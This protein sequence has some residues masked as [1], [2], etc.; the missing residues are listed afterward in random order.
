MKFKLLL[1]LGL[2]FLSSCQQGKK[3]IDPKL[4]LFY[5]EFSSDQVS[6]FEESIGY[7]DWFL[8]F[9]YPE[10]QSYGSSV[11]SFLKDFLRQD[12]AKFIWKHDHNKLQLTNEYLENSGLRKEFK[13]Y[14]REQSE[15]QN[16]S[17][18]P[19]KVEIEEEPIHLFPGEDSSVIESRRKKL[20]RMEKES[21]ERWDNSLHLNLWGNYLNAL[22]SVGEQ[23]KWVSDFV[24]A[25][26]ASNNTSP[27]IAAQGA[28]ESFS[29]NKFEDPILI[30][31]LFVEVF[32]WELLNE[33]ETY[34]LQVP[35]HEI[36]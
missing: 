21:M 14:G 23:E 5:H 15:Q 34:S 26:E 36:K 31:V 13:I 4:E 6:A 10:S 17:T 19:L 29:E 9:N 28:L 30:R 35:S 22:R 18:E 33:V 2:T 12:S 27:F 25:V 8:K 11:Q 24:E 3:A 1:T 32:Y 20:E 7:F 16:Q